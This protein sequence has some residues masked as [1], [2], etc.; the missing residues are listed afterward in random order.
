M[1]YFSIATIFFTRLCLLFAGIW[2]AAAAPVFLHLPK[3]ISW[4][5]QISLLLLFFAGFRKKNYHIMLAIAEISFLASFTAITPEQQFRNRRFMRQF[6]T[7]PS[8]IRTTGSNLFTVNNF[9]SN[10]YRTCEDYDDCFVSRTFDLG[11]VQSMDLAIVYWDGMSLVAHTMLQFNFSDG[12]K[13][14]I[15]V[16]PRTPVDSN[17]EPLT[18]LCRQQELLFIIG[19]PDDLLDLRSVY[20]GEDLYLYQTA[21]TPEQCRIILED[22]IAEVDRLNSDPRFYDLLTANC[23]TALSPSIKKG[24]PTINYDW[25]LI[26]NGYFDRMLFEQKLL[27]HRPGESFESLKSRSFIPGKS[28]GKL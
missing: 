19:S 13:L 21:F 4:I 11:K 12:Q 25:R 10:I 2:C 8:I 17:R 5:F 20:R 28:Q 6:E 27:C 24:C 14:V 26:F 15:S 9:R 23:I 1:K 3:T 22:I 18:C 7:K 16:E